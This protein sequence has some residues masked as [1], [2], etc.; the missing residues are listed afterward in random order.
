MITEKKVQKAIVQKS[1]GKFVPNIFL[2]KWESDL[3]KIAKDGVMTEYEIKCSHQDFT[4]D[5]IDKEEKHH[6]LDVGYD[7]SEIPNF[8]YFIC[9]DG[10]IR[11]SEIP[12][13]A[14][15]IYLVDQ[16][17]NKYLKTI[18][19]APILTS[20]RITSDMWKKIAN[21]LIDRLII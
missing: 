12:H 18:V 3:L 8:F 7:E 14:G 1:G 10:L 9:P 4:R 20:Q 15:L 21:S 17:M 5:F 6:A 19:K 2:Y 11:K 13:Y 16:G